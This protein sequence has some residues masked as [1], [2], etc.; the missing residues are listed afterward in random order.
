[1]FVKNCAK[2]KGSVKFRDNYM[3]LF[4]LYLFS[5]VVFPKSVELKN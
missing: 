3:M 4:M 2:T 1:M 5:E